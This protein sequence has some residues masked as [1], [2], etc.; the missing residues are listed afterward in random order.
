MTL[1]RLMWATSHIVLISTSFKFLWQECVSRSRRLVS[2][3]AAQQGWRPGRRRRGR[4]A[5]CCRHASSRRARARASPAYGTG[6]G[7]RCGAREKP[8]TSSL[9]G[10][11]EISAPFYWTEFNFGCV[12]ARISMFS[13]T[14]IKRLHCKKGYRFFHPQTDGMSLT[15]LFLGGN[16]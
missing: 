6:G 12:T 13:C 8:S 11:V 7:A 10:W 14:V 4:G 2:G 9:I 5:S 1:A 16:S 3:G 15:K